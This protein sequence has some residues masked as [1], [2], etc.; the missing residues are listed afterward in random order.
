MPKIH[1][2]TR[3]GYYKSKHWPAWHIDQYVITFEPFNIL[4][5]K[6]DF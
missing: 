3:G 5:N 6:K 4:E 2:H 1:P